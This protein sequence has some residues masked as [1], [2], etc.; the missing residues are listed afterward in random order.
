[1]IPLW[2]VVVLVGCLTTLAYSKMLVGKNKVDSASGMCLRTHIYSENADTGEVKWIMKQSCDGLLLSE[3]QVTDK[4]MVSILKSLQSGKKPFPLQVLDLRRNYL[5]PETITNVLSFIAKNGA[6]EALYLGGNGIN[7]DG[8]GI[9]NSILDGKSNA[10]K[11]NILS[12]EGMN[13]EGEDATRLARAIQQG[14]HK[15]DVIYLDHN[16]LSEE[17]EAILQDT[18]RA[19]RE[20]S[21]KR[22]QTPVDIVHPA[23][24][25]HSNSPVAAL[26]AAERANANPNPKAM[27]NINAKAKAKAKAM[28]SISI[29]D[30]EA[31]KNKK[32]PIISVNGKNNKRNKGKEVD[33]PV[34]KPVVDQLPPDPIPPEDS[35]E[36][37]IYTF[38]EVAP[39]LHYCELDDPNPTPNPNPNPSSSPSP[40]P[41][42][43]SNSNSNSTPDGVSLLHKLELAGAVDS[44]HLTGLDAMDFDRMGLNPILRIKL[45]KCICRNYIHSH[46]RG[47]LRATGDIIAVAARLPALCRETFK[48]MHKASVRSVRADKEA[49]RHT[50]RYH[51]EVRSRIETDIQMIQGVGIGG[52]G[53]RDEGVVEVDVNEDGS[54]RL[55]LPHS[56][57]T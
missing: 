14:T 23:L 47:R 24:R 28:A 44:L 57:H 19:R 33:V 1:M 3:N 5:L 10:V 25:I 54:V 27:V 53:E 37:G 13:I 8:L 31:S 20:T 32:K 17:A 11:L 38:D 36:D 35:F 26:A 4:D 48:L 30:S 6:I 52:E 18:S 41:G 55:I 21:N 50:E 49:S 56:S 40:N 46:Q 7:R 16:P 22:A 43:D 12:L 42:S 9:L 15:L 2:Y 39:L 34:P 51:R 45:T 29:S